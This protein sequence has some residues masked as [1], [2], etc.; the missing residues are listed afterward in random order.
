MTTVTIVVKI[1]PESEVDAVELASD[2]A[3]LIRET[4]RDTGEVESVTYKVEEEV[5]W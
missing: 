1:N 4:G 5:P 3:D 2:Y